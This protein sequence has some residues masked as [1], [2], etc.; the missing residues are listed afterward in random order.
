MSGFEIIGVVLG[1]LP[2][3]CKGIDNYAATLATANRLLRPRRELRSLRC[4]INTELQIFKNTASILLLNI[5]NEIDASQLIHE[6]S[7]EAWKDPD[8]EG[9]LKNLL[10]PSHAAWCEILGDVN[11]AVKEI[12]SRLKLPNDDVSAHEK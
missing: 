2:L 7:A 9:K 4:S 8:F 12:R 11:N 10:G 6:P 5:T 1:A 3:L